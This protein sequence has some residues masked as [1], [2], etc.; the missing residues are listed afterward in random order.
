M[1]LKEILDKNLAVNVSILRVAKLWTMYTV[2]AMKAAIPA[3]TIR[4]LN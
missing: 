2:L 1:T 3:N 4:R